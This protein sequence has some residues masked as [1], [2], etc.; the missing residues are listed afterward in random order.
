VR[1]ITRPE[2]RYLLLSLLIL[3]WAGMTFFVDTY[4]KFEAKFYREIL[5]QKIALTNYQLTQLKHPRCGE[6][7]CMDSL[8]FASLGRRTESERLNSGIVSF[9]TELF[10]FDNPKIHDYIS[11]KAESLGYELHPFTKETLLVLENTYRTQ[12]EVR[13]AYRA[14]QQAMSRDGIALHFVSGYRD[15]LHQ[16]ELFL[17]RLGLESV[18]ESDILSGV[19]DE[20]LNEVLK[21]TAPPGYS[22]HHTGFTVDFA[23]DDKYLVYEFQTTACYQ[24]M[25]ENNFER[26]KSFGFIPSYPEGLDIQGP[27]PEAWEYIWVGK[28]AFK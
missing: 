16:Q 28:N 1:H 22:K 2:E 20:L 11:K 5:V 21:R 27:Q 12:P 3:V 14:M 15:Y 18:T 23:C 4:G 10:M 6:F 13:S 26:I 9:Q 25:S 24:W 19:H 7:F 8:G 17:D